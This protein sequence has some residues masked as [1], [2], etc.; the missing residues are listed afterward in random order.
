MKITEYHPFK[1]ADAKKTYLEFYDKKSEDWPI[2]S[3][4]KMI[5]T[6]YGETFVRISGPLNAPALVLLTGFGGNSSDWIPQIKDLSENFRTYA[7]DNI[8]DNGKSVYTKE[9]SGPED[10]TAWL[11]DLLIAIGLNNVNL[12]GLSYGGWLTCE[13]ALAHPEKLNKMVILAPAATVLPVS[14]EMNIKMATLV[15]SSENVD[16]FVQWLYKDAIE[17]DEANLE[18]VKTR[19]QDGI[20]YGSCFKPKEIIPPRVLEDDELNNI[21][22]PGLF[23][24]GEND[25]TYSAQ[26]AL[27]RINMAAPMIKTE[28]IPKAGHDL[29]LSQNDM[30]IR[31]VLDFLEHS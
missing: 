15:E 22:V 17:K 5:S 10:F 7:V 24:V 14:S 9:L 4:S 8:Y 21:Q 18:R 6:S 26:E 27:E 20:I 19:M 16:N 25:K 12:M 28:I 13:Y 23:I 3:E 30:V 2:A 31:K 1:S 29:M 11:D